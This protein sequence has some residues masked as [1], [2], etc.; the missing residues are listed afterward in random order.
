MKKFK[1]M[2]LILASAVAL[3]AC[4]NESTEVDSKA[5]EEDKVFYIGAIPDQDAAL[6]QNNMDKLA[7]YLSEETGLNVEYTSSVDYAALVTGFERSEVHMAWFGGLTS[8]QAMAVAPEAQ[9]IVQRPRDE[10][11]TSVFVANPSLGLS[12][13]EDVKGKSLTFGSESSTSGHL[14]PRHFITE[15]GINV[16]TDLSQAPNFSGS[17]DTTYKLVEAGTYEVGALNSAVWETAVKEN[18]VDTSKVDVFYVTPEYYDYNFTI[19]NVDAEFGEGTVEKVK[20]ALLAMDEEQ[21]EI[22]DFFATDKFIE[23]KNENYDA[24]RDVAKSLGIIK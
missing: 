19:N 5:N 22:L 13:L 21:K 9:A 12:S 14:M 15:A 16:E 23:T 24:I 1:F 17:H 7:D 6:L 3:V 4:G 11:F 18:K 20:A 2:S 8:V 10:Q